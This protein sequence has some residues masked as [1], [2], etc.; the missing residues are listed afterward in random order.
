[1]YL[2]ETCSPKVG[3]AIKLLN[4][5][6]GLVVAV[7]WPAGRTVLTSGEWDR[8]EE[9]QQDL[10]TLLSW[11]RCGPPPRPELNMYGMHRHPNHLLAA[12]RGLMTNCQD[13]PGS[14]VHG[15]LVQ[16]CDHELPLLASW[17]V[18]QANTN[19]VTKKKKKQKGRKK[20]MGNG[21][22]TILNYKYKLPLGVGQ[23]CTFCLAC[24]GVH[25]SSG[26]C[27]LVWNRVC[28]LTRQNSEWAAQVSLHIRDAATNR[29]Y[30]WVLADR[31]FL[32]EL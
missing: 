14:D 5:P 10:Q 21:F 29:H 4:L 28:C 2:L 6:M 12:W 25:W 23:P 9:E 31:F 19:V 26:F 20:K 15:N 22:R 8:L 32:T 3:E 24:L 1:M 11:Q 27:S 18:R 30:I 13:E 16:T 17:S 7:A